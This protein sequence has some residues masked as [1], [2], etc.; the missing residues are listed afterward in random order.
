M[1]PDWDGRYASVPAGDERYER[2]ATALAEVGT[3]DLL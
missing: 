2:Y 3:C 1:D